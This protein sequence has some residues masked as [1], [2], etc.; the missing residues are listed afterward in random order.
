MRRFVF[1]LALFAASCATVQTPS[2]QLATLAEEHWQRQIESDVSTR[3]SLGM[4]IDRLPD[5]SFEQAERDADVSRKLLERLNRIDASKLSE[6]EQVSLDILRHLHQLNVDGLPHFWTQFQVTP[7]GSPIRG[8]QMVF[9]QLPFESSED[10]A[11][12]V[13][14]LE[15]YGRFIDRLTAV[16]QEQQ[17]RGILIPKRELPAVK[18]LLTSAALAVSPARLQAIPE[19]ERAVFLDAMRNAITLSVNPAL[20]RLN[21]VLAKEYEAA[22][23]DAVGIGQYPGGPEAYRWL[24]RYH[25]SYD[26]TPQELHETGLRELERIDRELAEV[27]AAMSFTGPKRE[28]YPFLQQYWTTRGAFR[29]PQG[30]FST[31]VQRIEPHVSRFFSVTPRAPYDTQRLAPSLETTMTFGYYQR[32]TAT[33]ATGHY[34][35]NGS[36]S[37]PRSIIFGSALMAHE[38]IPGHHFQIA[39]QIESEDLPMWRRERYDTVYVEGWGEYAAMLAAEM[40]LYDMPHDRAGRLMMDALVSTRL[41]VDTGL[42]AFGWSYEKA[43]DFMREHTPLTDEEIDTEILRYAVDIPGQALAYKTGAMKIMEMRRA[44]TG[45]VRAF[46]EW[47]LRGGSVPLSL[48]QRGAARAVPASSSK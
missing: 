30:H 14:L 12:Y 29:D 25:T 2:Q 22:A 21:A 13:R 28:F 7:Y 47:M 11:R 31:Y 45:D 19:A 27:R 40:G 1:A 17:R 38:L 33:D 35:Y 20:A 18:T 39:R 44:W 15:E 6:E 42:N 9:M 8:L 3:S 4:P 16:V 10:T 48:K 36:P 46:H 32:P 24:I 23:P 26:L 37:K 43:R 41:V 5:P 34:Y